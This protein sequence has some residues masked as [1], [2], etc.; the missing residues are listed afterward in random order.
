MFLIY[1]LIAGLVV[2]V[3]FGSLCRAGGSGPHDEE[4]DYLNRNHELYRPGHPNY[5]SWADA[6]KVLS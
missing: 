4:A 5:L 2:S 3:G 6:P 1:W